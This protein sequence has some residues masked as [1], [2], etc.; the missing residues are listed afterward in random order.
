M[1]Y[2][3]II[4]RS[5]Y[6]VQNLPCFLEKWSKNLFEAQAVWAMFCK[7]LNPLEV[8]FRGLLN[9]FFK[10][11]MVPA[12]GTIPKSNEKGIF[13]IILAGTISYVFSPF[14]QYCREL[15]EV[16]KKFG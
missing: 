6:I 5:G 3:K 4:N 13:R 7:T 15:F 1:F 12:N 8:P 11:N 16:N 9:C 2:D 10:K 14:Y